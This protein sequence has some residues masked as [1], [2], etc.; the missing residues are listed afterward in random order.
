[1]SAVKWVLN[2][3]VALIAALDEVRGVQG[4]SSPSRGPFTLSCQVGAEPGRD[5][6]LIATQD[7]VGVG[8][9]GGESGE[10]SSQ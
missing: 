7:K 5:R 4:V 6:A 9:E 8:G 1:M 10:P 2:Q 3:A